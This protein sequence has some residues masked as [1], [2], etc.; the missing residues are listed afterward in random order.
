MSD[1]DRHPFPQGRH[2]EPSFG[3]LKD[4]WKRLED[5]KG[6]RAFLRRA[7]T[8]TQVMLSPSFVDLLRTLR[9]QDYSIG[10]YDLPLSKIAAIAGLSARIESLSEESLATRMG[11]PKPGAS[12]P[13]FSELRLRRILA[14]D[15]IEELYVQLRRAIAILD[16]T[17]NLADLAATIWNWSPMDAKRPRDPRRQ[18]AYDYYSVAPLKP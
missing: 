2:E 11:T 15:D 6:E 1:I 17:V 16:D 4:W 3:L 5:N 13:A 18:I 8:L 7:S 14:C 9:N 10:G 12:T